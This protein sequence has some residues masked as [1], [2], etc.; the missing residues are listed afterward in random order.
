MNRKDYKAMMHEGRTMFALLTAPT[1]RARDDCKHWDDTTEAWSIVFNLVYA[2]VGP[3]FW[4][5]R[6][7]HVQWYASTKLTMP[8]AMKANL[9][10]LPNSYPRQDD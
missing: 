1:W 7:Q 9:M 8:Y 2:K 5:C 4:E 6:P 10:F 3:L